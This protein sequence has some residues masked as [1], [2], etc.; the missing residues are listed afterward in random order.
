MEDGT[1]GDIR[2]TLALAFSRSDFSMNFH[3]KLTHEELPLVSRQ[4]HINES[5]R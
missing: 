1:W 5:R 3:L 4:M 2:F